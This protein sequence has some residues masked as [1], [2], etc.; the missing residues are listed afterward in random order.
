[1]K[2][3][4]YDEAISI[5][6]VLQKPYAVIHFRLGDRYGLPL[7]NCSEF[8]ATPL[9]SFDFGG[10]PNWFDPAMPPPPATWEAVRFGCVKRTDETNGSVN[11]VTTEMA[12]AAWDLASI[13]PKIRDV[14]IAT[15]RPNNPRVQKLKVLLQDRN[16]TPWTWEDLLSERSQS[17]KSHGARDGSIIGVMEQVLAIEAEAFLPAFPSSWDSVAITR[18]QACGK[19]QAGSHHELALQS[20]LRFVT[21]FDGLKCQDK[22]WKGS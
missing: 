4:L 18:R 6:G 17:S 3:A 21:R 11:Y 14:Y 20:L 13:N 2:Q 15:N 1:V 8:L 22:H 9:Q 5:S 7:V 16:L 10:F 19:P 12:A